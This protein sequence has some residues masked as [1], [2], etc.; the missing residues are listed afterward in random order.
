MNIN[1]VAIYN[2]FAQCTAFKVT[3]KQVETSSEWQLEFYPVIRWAMHETEKPKCKTRVTLHSLSPDDS[4]LCCKVFRWYSLTWHPSDTCVQ[5]KDTTLPSSNPNT[6]HIFR[7]LGKVIWGHQWS[8]SE[9]LVIPYLKLGRPDWLI[10][11]MWDLLR[12]EETYHFGGIL[13]VIWG[14]WDL[15]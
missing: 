4:S 12:L 8:K 6:S 1:G 2:D 11:G 13:K 3:H 14:H 7:L 15:C 10:A 5:H 9:R